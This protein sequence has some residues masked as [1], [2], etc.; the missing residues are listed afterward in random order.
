ML[1]QDL[2]KDG[3]KPYAPT[4][5]ER[6]FDRVLSIFAPQR[7]FLNSFYRE[8]RHAF[9][10]EGARITRLRENATRATH[11]LIRLTAF[12]WFGRRAILR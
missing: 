5:I 1:T 9:G 8:R 2:R 4:R 12:N 3:Y 7:A 11:R 6:G 10:Y